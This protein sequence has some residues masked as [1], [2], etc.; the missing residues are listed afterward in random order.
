MK[1]LFIIIT[2][3]LSISCK[4][5]TI[6][7]LNTS[8]LDVPDSNYY[9]K[10][11]NNELNK[12][13]GTWKYENGNTSFTIVFTKKEKVKIT[14]Y[15]KDF[16]SGNYIYIVDGVEIIN[17]F[18]MTSNN[19]FIWGGNINPNDN[20]SLYNAQFKDPERPKVSVHA[21]LDYI[22]N[23]MGSLP[24]LRLQL[25]KIGVSYTMVGEPDPQQD[26]RVPTD[27]ILTKQ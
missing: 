10:D 23:G 6:V 2:A 14:D 4:A 26:F 7:P 8:S 25:V 15:Y 11:L 27:I 1:H 19:G 18:T 24:S 22:S 17:T 13:I 21:H 5:Q 9:R 16:I 3:I 12:F 20:K